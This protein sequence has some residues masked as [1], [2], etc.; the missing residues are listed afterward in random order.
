MKDFMHK[1]YSIESA[2]NGLIVTE[3]DESNGIESKHV[4]ADY[5]SMVRFIQVKLESFEPTA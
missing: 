4:F 1:T 5:M 3:K 2:E